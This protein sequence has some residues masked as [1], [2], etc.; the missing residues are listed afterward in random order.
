MRRIGLMLTACVGLMGCAA[1]APEPAA[2]VAATDLAN[3]AATFCVG[4]GNQYL[5]R[6]G[7]GGSVGICILPDGSEVDAWD[8]FRANGPAAESGA[9]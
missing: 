4:E 6:S 5:I 3:P 7:N 8:Y 9:E 2:E 1:A